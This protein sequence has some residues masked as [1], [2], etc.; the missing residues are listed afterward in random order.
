MRGAG[1]ALIGQGR[2]RETNGVPPAGRPRPEGAGGA[3]AGRL[4]PLPRNPR[5]ELSW[6]S[7]ERRPLMGLLSP[8]LSETCTSSAGEVCLLEMLASAG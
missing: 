2:F 7:G 3:G 5:V 6:C 4:S 1:L 8:F